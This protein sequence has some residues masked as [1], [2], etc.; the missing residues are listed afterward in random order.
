VNRLSA[1]RTDPEAGMVTRPHGPP[2]YTYKDHVCVDGGK[3][4][5]VTAVQVTP[6][7][8][9]DEAQLRSLIEAHSELLG[10]MPRRVAADTKYGTGLNYQYLF[11]RGIA[12][13]IPMPEL[14]HKAKEF[15]NDAF[16]YDPQADVYWCP[17]SKPLYRRG[18]APS[19]DAVIYRADPRDCR[20]CPVRAQCTTSPQGRRILRRYDQEYRDLAKVH[21]ATEQARLDLRR[22]RV[23]IEGIFADAKQRHGLARARG[24][25]LT[26]VSIQ[27][28]LIASV[29][30][31]KK[32]AR[33]GAPRGLA[34][35]LH[36]ELFA[37]LQ[38][39]AGKLRPTLHQRLISEHG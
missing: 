37:W 18:D 26:A 4:R 6:G 13:S 29:Q 36:A 22:R 24:R 19:S 7:H 25:G 30:N 21:L 3:A 12:P 38:P 9:P 1:S 11:E 10:R 17:T 28:L 8:A 16:G 33:A 23:W 5:I 32:M 35:A 31:I 15:S 39:P 20:V 34:Q 27:A 2:R 14:H